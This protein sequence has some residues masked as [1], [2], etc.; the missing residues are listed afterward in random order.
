M[1]DVGGL[2]GGLGGAVGTIFGGVGQLAAAGGYEKA[3]EIAAINAQISRQSSAI[4]QTQA[5]REI[6]KTLGGQQ[7]DIAGAGL[8]AAGSALDIVR[9]SAQ[10]GA[11]AKQLIAAQGM[12]TTLGYEQ[13]SA[14][15]SAMAKAAKASG[16]GGI[17]GGLLQ[18]A[19]AVASFLA[20][21][22]ERA[23]TDVQLRY[24][25]PDGLGIYAFRYK[26][27]KER[28]LF[29]GV[30]AQEVAALYPAAVSPMADGTLRVD[31]DAINVTPRVLEESNG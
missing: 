7:A 1:A 12:I 17:L 6:Y 3:S 24:R 15:Y 8:A 4:Q 28:T 13:E 9:S 22:D 29:E 10:Q 14:S 19:G 30:M 27:D 21:S 16:G 5:Q 2:L 31:Y 20:L 23:K 25:R 18:G 11:L 26:G